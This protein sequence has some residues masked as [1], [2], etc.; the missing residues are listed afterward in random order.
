MI[1]NCLHDNKPFDA[2]FPNQ[3]YC[4][5]NCQLEGKREKDR[6]AH[7]KYD[8]NPIVKSKKIHE[9]IG[10]FDLPKFKYT[11][12]EEIPTDSNLPVPAEWYHEYKVIQ[13]LKKYHK[14]MST[15]YDKKKSSLGSYR[16]ISFDEFNKFSITY[17][18]ENCAPCPICG[19]TIQEKDLKHS[20]IICRNPDC[21]GH[22]GVVIKGNQ[23]GINYPEFKP[24]MAVSHEDV[25]IANKGRS[26]EDPI[27]TTQEIQN[28]AWIRFRNNE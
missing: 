4:S 5:E 12:P 2:Q 3:R 18:L 15:I 20:E 23:Q 14:T 10:T 11:L 8:N 24:K 22:G 7:R 26:F 13:N 16:D 21:L 25:G 28:V 17:P 27:A 6:R 1:K 19:E 9:D